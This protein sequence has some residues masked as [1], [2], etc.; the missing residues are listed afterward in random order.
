MYS[1]VD[2]ECHEIVLVEDTYN[3]NSTSQAF[4]MDDAFITSRTGKITARK[5]TLDWA[6][7][8]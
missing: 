6:L 1:Q 2:L 5:T 3:H 7:L 8:C 4:S